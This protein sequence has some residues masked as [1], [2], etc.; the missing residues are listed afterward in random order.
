MAKPAILNLL[1]LFLEVKLRKALLTPKAREAAWF[2]LQACFPSGSCRPSKQ[3]PYLAA[4]EIRK[5]T[6]GFIRAREG[7]IPE[8]KLLPGNKNPSSERKRDL[9]FPL[10]FLGFLSQL[11]PLSVHYLNIWQFLFRATNKPGSTRKE[12]SIRKQWASLRQGTVN[13]SLPHQAEPAH[14]SVKFCKTISFEGK[15]ASVLALA[16]FS[17]LSWK[18][19]NMGVRIIPIL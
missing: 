18:L 2:T 1:T 7:R 14:L 12:R 3:R 15:N 11:S 5:T 9:N 13:V 10:G 17:Q 19:S 8:Q 6:D 4:R 16:H